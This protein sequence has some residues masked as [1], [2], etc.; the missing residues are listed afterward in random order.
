MKTLRGLA[1]ALITILLTIGLLTAIRVSAGQAAPTSDFTTKIQTTVADFNQG[2]FYLTGMTRNDDGEVTLLRLGIA[3]EWRT[4]SIPTG[5]VPRYEHA[6]IAYNNRLY[7]FGGRISASASLRSIQFTDIN[8]VTHDV[9]NWITAT[10]S[11]ASSIYTY[12]SGGNGVAG[13]SAVQLNGRVYLLGGHD[14]SHAILY[15]TVSFATI[16]TATGQLGALA[17]TAPLP[18]GLA[19]GQ[20]V[21][22]DNRIYYMGGM[23]TQTLRGTNTVYYA[24]PDPVT[25]AISA[26][27]TTTTPLPYGTYGQMAVATVNDRIYSMAGI[28][29]TTLK[30]SV[31][32]VFY[33]QPVAATGDI[34][35]WVKAQELPRSIFDGA[36]VTFGG[37]IYGTGGLLDQQVS[38]PS[39]YVV[40]GFDLLD[41]AVMTWTATRG[42]TPSRLLHTAVV[43]ADGWLYIVGGSDGDLQPIQQNIINIAATTGQTGTEYA[44]NGNFSSKPFDFDKN[45]ILHQLSWATTLPTSTTAALQYRSRLIGGDYT[46]WSALY[47][48]TLGTGVVTTTLPVTITARYLQ[49]QVF[50][51]TTDP[52][53]TPILHHVSVLAEK[54]VPPTFKKSSDPISGSSVHPGDRIT[55]TLVYSNV[56]DNAMTH[57]VIVDPVLTTTTY[58]ADSISGPDGV[59]ITLDA[60]QLS[61]TVGTLPAH[62]GGTIGFAVTVNSDEPEGSII[63]NSADFRSDQA[64]ALS[65]RTYHTVGLPPELVKSHISSA[66][67][68]ALGQVQPGDI[69]TYTLA[70]TNQ[71]QIQPLLNTLITDTLPPGLTYLGATGPL[72]PTVS[73]DPVNG[74]QVLQWSIGTVLSQTH[75]AVGFYAQVVTNT[76][77]VPNGG[78]I[79]N[80]AFGTAGQWQFFSDPDSVPVR[81]RFDLKLSID[82]GVA[83]ATEDSVLTYTIRIT[84]VTSVPITP[85]G[86]VI[87]DALKPGR[88]TNQP[89]VLRC[90]SPCA[91]WTLAGLDED[92]S[93]VYSQTIPSLGPNQTA[94]LTLV[95]QV[96]PTLLTDAPGVL[97]LA[98]QASALDDGQQGIEDD[99]LN[100]TAVDT[101]T[102]GIPPELVKSHL[103]SAP[104]QALGRVQPG[105]VVTYTLA[106]TNPSLV[107]PLLNTIITDSLPPSLTY[108]GGIGAPLPT[109]STD[110]LSG[111]QVLQWSVG[112]VQAQAHGAVSFYARVVT[113]TTLVPNEGS[114]AN[115]AFGTSDQWRFSSNTDSVPVRYRFDLRLS[116]DD[117]VTHAT[118]GS[119]LTYTI[120][121]TNITSVPITPTGIVISDTLKPGIPTNQPGVL[122]CVSL[123]AG[124]TLVGLDGGGSQVYSQT[125]P[126]LGPNQ[127]AVLTLVAQVSPTLLTDAPSVLAVANQ[128][129]ALDDG[130][131]G[132]EA[133]PLNQA[134]EDIDIASGPDLVVTDLQAINQAIVPG[135]PVQFVATLFNDGFVTTVSAD[136]FSWF[137]VDLYVKPAGAPPPS[138]PA[139]RR[140]GYCLDADNY[141]CTVESSHIDWVR[142]G[143]AANATLPITFTTSITS[144]GTY[145]LYAQ[146]DLY[147]AS[148]IDMGDYT[149]GTPAHGRILEGNER[150]NS[151][152]PLIVQVGTEEVDNNLYLPLIH[153]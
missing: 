149:P 29:V 16:F 103:S 22:L 45:Y 132:L 144:A 123:C 74:R 113:D 44:P 104:V 20:A 40:A 114:L 39:N 107:Q 124:W 26:W 85:T 68:Q 101:D 66:P 24:T 12:T 31:P 142:D 94:V 109:V 79:A 141:P 139:D 128:A 91:D 11:L 153:K 15:N 69:V 17:P 105:D 88:P 121:I 126:S 115:T 49:Y 111:R 59:T 58:V 108:L 143:L 34:T 2:S 57:V 146:A 10:T 61:W 140:L 41:T 54:P 1:P 6:S 70:Y 55:Y 8:T 130:Q 93:L 3:G 133:N 148:L 110:P 112:E 89:G 67:V 135:Q 127:T 137:T 9:G 63:Y 18:Q 75:G 136:G 73:T 7:V 118:G 86:I 84:N 25:G 36:A 100:Q 90:V 96:S 21:V 65:N 92:G 78:S 151:F 28:T 116:V 87:S 119:V 102:V 83:Y 38:I 60:S 48:S 42:I 97:E 19:H 32:Y 82:D 23:F 53:A 150:N 129:S 95:A 71:N 81:Y 52:L 122:R 62:T 145:W 35:T 43:N 134:A 64:D 152:G 47:P 99:P 27:Y 72:T 14:G 37:Q 33:A 80:M 56:S 106:Y 5:F 50:F 76:T 98:N 51:T 117:G 120:R 30:G 4:D 131:Q 138:G 147:W 125:I 77:L 46:P 13:L